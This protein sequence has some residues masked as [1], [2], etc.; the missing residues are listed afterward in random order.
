MADINLQ[1]V[2]EYFELHVF[3]VLTNWRQEPWRGRT[4]ES[5]PQLF[6]E[7]A[8]PVPR[9]EPPLLLEPTDLRGIERAVVHVRAWHADRF[10]PSV[11][12][13]SPVLSQFERDEAGAIAEYVFG[14]QPCVTILVISE[15]PASRDL[16]ERSMQLLHGAGVDHVIEFP[17]ILCGLL[18]QVSV[19]G[20][21]TSS[22]TLQT[23]RLLK[24]YKLVRAQQLEFTFPTEPPLQS[25]LLRNAE[26]KGDV[27]AEE[28]ADDDGSDAPEPD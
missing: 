13:S 17:T 23:L 11:I 21:Y 15:L 22:A 2:R 9:V 4:A 3:R 8:R 12:G 19:N 25:G 16:R 14:G 24:R 28:R 5:S 27:A 26:G 6:V 18:D 10:Y 1:L 20:N 7:N